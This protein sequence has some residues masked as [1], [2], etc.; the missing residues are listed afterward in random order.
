MADWLQNVKATT[1]KGTISLF[2]VKNPA[3]GGPACLATLDLRR[4][5][6]TGRR[7]GHRGSVLFV[8]HASGRSRRGVWPPGAHRYSRVGR[9]H[10]KERR[11]SRRVQGRRPHTARASDGV[12]ALR[13]VVVRDARQPT[14]AGVGRRQIAKTFPSGKSD[15]MLFWHPLT[16]ERVAIRLAWVEQFNPPGRFE[17]VFWR[18]PSPRAPQARS[19]P[20]RRT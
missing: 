9:C 4:Q 15:R 16:T 6:E 14:Y 13:F 19:L 10:G 11:V 17:S 20:P 1:T 3:L 8:Q 2:D 5:R 18:A 12:H 7:S